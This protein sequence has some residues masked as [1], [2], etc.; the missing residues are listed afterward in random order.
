MSINKRKNTSKNKRISAS[1]KV[2]YVIKRKRKPGPK[3]KR[4]PKKKKKTEWVRR[5]FPPWEFKVIICNNK[6]QIKYLGRY[7]DEQEIEQIKLSLLDN[8]SKVKLP[9]ISLNDV[10]EYLA[11][12]RGEPTCIYEC[13]SVPFSS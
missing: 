11:F 7:H 6:K 9:T 3:K 5:I 8:N 4:G 13:L 10:N 2:Y 1:G 12:S